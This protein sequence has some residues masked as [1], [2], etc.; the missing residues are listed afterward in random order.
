[1][2]SLE[3]EIDNEPAQ[4][5]LLR[6][7]YEENHFKEIKYYMK[8]FL[9]IHPANLNVL[10]GLA[11]AQYG[12]DCFDDAR[13]TLDLILVFNPEHKDALELMKSIPAKV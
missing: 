1:M 3:R 11:G 8:N 5:H 13:N 2:R 12:S 9:E 10:F 4:N 6:V 7:S